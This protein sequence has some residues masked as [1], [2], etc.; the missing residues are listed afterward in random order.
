VFDDDL[1]SGISHV[2]EFLKY[3][4]RKGVGHED[5]QIKLFIA[6]LSFTLQ[7]WIKI[8]SFI[9]LLSKF[10]KYCTPSLQTY[11]DTLQE[12]TTSLKRE[13]FF[14]DHLVEDLREAHHAQEEDSI[15]E[16]DALIIVPLVEEDEEVCEEPE[17]CEDFSQRLKESVKED[18]K[19]CKELVDQCQDV[20]LLIDLCAQR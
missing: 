17:Q 16:D 14:P 7:R 18:K 8:S 13:G 12:L 2:V 10:L 11:E 1:S 9:D 6:S 5:V 3:I 20:H 19:F 15:D 4:Q